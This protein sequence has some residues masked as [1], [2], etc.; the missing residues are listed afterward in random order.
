[1]I[2]KVKLK[3]ILISLIIIS[4]PITLGLIF[5]NFTL[6]NTEN[7]ELIQIS[8]I[9]HHD[10]QPWLINSDFNGAG[11]PWVSNIEGDSTDLSTSISSGQADYQVNG[12]IRTFSEVSGTP[13]SDDWTLFNHSIRPLPLTYEINEFGCNV[14]HVYD[15]DGTGPFPNSGDQTANLAAALW[16]RNLTIPV[17]MSDYVITSASINAVVNGSADMDIETPSD[18][19]PFAEGGYASLFDFTRFY[20]EISDLNNVESYEIAYNK[21]LHLGQGYAARRD[22]DSSTRNYMSDTNMTTTDEDVLI[23]ALTQVLR[24]DNHNFTITLG[25]DVD[26]EDNYPGYELDV[27]YSL[28]IKSCDLTFTYEKKMDKS[29][30][31][32]FNQIGDQI[33]GTNVKIKDGN[34]SFRYMIDQPWPTSLSPNSEIRVLINGKQHSETLKLSSAPTGFQNAKLGGFNITS[35]L[36]VEINISVSIQ[37][38]IADEFNLDRDIIISID[39]VILL[40]SYSEELP[41]PIDDPWLAAGFFILASVGTAVLGALLIVYIKVWRY[42]VPVRKVRK[43]GKTLMNT[44]NPD[45]KIIERKGAFNKGYHEVL[46]KSSRLLKGSPTSDK[47]NTDNLLKKKETLLPK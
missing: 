15:E 22:Y 1:M 24:H 23:F 30:A 42:P 21:T 36:N 8:A 39:E 31:V 3:R 46:N 7:T 5:N 26:S 25:I 41:D 33:T 40:I 20:V 34:I 47:V 37:V 12:D 4:I 17:D 27:W 45:V 43:Y 2:H 10:N 14:S 18:H 44:K 6:T 28:L 16:K 32:S 13:T 9:E 35:L 29:S 19:P 11:A 38:F